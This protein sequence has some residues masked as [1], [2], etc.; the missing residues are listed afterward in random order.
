MLKVSLLL[1]IAFGF[2]THPGSALAQQNSRVFEE[3]DIGIIRYGYNEGLGAATIYGITYSPNGYVWAHTNVGVYLFNGFQ[4]QNLPQLSG[5]EIIYAHMM[6]DSLKAVMSFD[7]TINLI[8]TENISASRE[9]VLPDS[10]RLQAFAMSSFDDDGRFLFGT[11]DGRVLVYNKG[12]WSQINFPL[13]KGSPLRIAII[14][15]MND[16]L[17]YLTTSG[18]FHVVNGNPIYI[19]TRDSVRGKSTIHNGTA[20]TPV[21]DGIARV[22]DWGAEL[23][24]SR[25]ALGIESLITHLGWVSDSEL[26]ITTQSDGIVVAH[27]DSSYTLLR[28]EKLYPG[29]FFTGIAL[30]DDGSVWVSSLNEGIYR[31]QP[32]FRDFRDRRHINGTSLQQVVFAD[33]HPL[34]EEIILSTRFN[35][36]FQTRGSDSWNTVLTDNIE[37][38]NWLNENELFLSRDIGFD[39]YNVVERRF[40]KRYLGSEFPN[41]I[42]PPVKTADSDGRYIVISAPNG[43]FVLNTENDN[44]VFEQAGRATSAAFASENRLVIGQPSNLM[45]S[46]LITGEVLHSWPLTVNDLIGLDST[47]FV[48]A[49]ATN[50]LLLLDTESMSIHTLSKPDRLR[51]QSWSVVRRLTETMVGVA[52]SMGAFIVDISDFE[53]GMNG[54]SIYDVPLRPFG[55]GQTVRDFRLVHDHLWISSGNGVIEIPLRK[56]LTMDL[57]PRLVISRLFV[58]EQEVAFTQSKQLRTG[59]QQLRIELSNNGFQNSERY[60]LEFRQGGVQSE[61]VVLNQPTVLL[62][63]IPVRESRYDFR[64]RDL[65]TGE[66]ISY[67]HLDVFRTPYWWQTSAGLFLIGIMLVISGIGTTYTVQQRI[68]KR[69]V[70]A[71]ERADQIRKLE[72]V[73]V[74]QLL[75]THYVFNA[76]TTIRALMHKSADEAIEYISTFAQVIRVLVDQSFEIDV[77]L[78]TELNWIDDYLSLEATNRGIHL[79]YSLRMDERIDLTQIAIPSFT[80]QPIFENALTHGRTPDRRLELIC[81]IKRIGEQID[82]IITNSYHQK[83]SSQQRAKPTEQGESPA[84]EKGSVGLKLMKDRLINWI[85]FHKMKPHERVV[86]SELHEGRWVTHLRIPY[87]I[88]D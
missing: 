13:D 30:D 33:K 50:G 3:S 47:R 85:E 26:W 80:L 84:R 42:Q 23:L 19:R 57:R 8:N 88:Y 67:T 27:V 9:L 70:E 45:I 76:L 78:Q 21:N 1:F 68:Q 43:T 74:T 56:I 73:A 61:W 86:T 16:D 65:L 12:D 60:T 59:T 62:A 48:I 35:G 72:R 82:I 75:T 6:N 4:F 79:D 69:K 7:N 66:S 10:M 34:T 41:H 87:I 25:Q 38:A 17:I 14:H 53:P 32:W 5:K 63:Q 31:F 11:S 24:F 83:E 44:V 37:Y 40:R 55:L 39:I 28:S 46:D 22:T 58:D 64:F 81:E 2:L 49:T 36:T 15:R 18:T 52:G 51:N 77:D 20:W 54:A 29:V 71:F